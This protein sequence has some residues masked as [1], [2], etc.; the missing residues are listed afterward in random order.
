M[1]D[2]IFPGALKVVENQNGKRQHSHAQ[3][4]VNNVVKPDVVGQICY[5][6]VLN[7]VASGNNTPE[8]T[9]NVGSCFLPENCLDYG[10]S[11]HQESS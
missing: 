3:T 1:S 7:P 2:G 10:W 6:K 4:N 8:E 5:I 11:R 9:V